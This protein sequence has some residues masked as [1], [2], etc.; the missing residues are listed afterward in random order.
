MTLFLYVVRTIAVYTLA[1]VV[2]ITTLYILFDII[3]ASRLLTKLGGGAPLLL[4][5]ASDRVAAALWHVLPASVLVGGCLAL[6][7]LARRGE[8][9]AIAA[10]G[11]GPWALLAPALLV[12]CLAATASYAV[13]ELW[14][15]GANRR[16]QS[17]LERAIV[18]GSGASALS[19]QGVWARE[20]AVLVHTGRMGA[21]VGEGHEVTLFVLDAQF[22]PVRRI[23]AQRM[24]WVGSRRVEGAVAGGPWLLEGAIERSFV[25]PDGT[26][27]APTFRKHS[28]LRAPLD[29][30]P[31]RLR[32]DL[33]RPELLRIG[34]LRAVAAWR[35]EQGQ[36]AYSFEAAFAER[37]SWPLLAIG[38]VLLLTP[39][40]LRSRASG[41]PAAAL[42]RAVLIAASYAAVAIA[43]QALG[44]ADVL[45]GTAVGALAPALL[46]VAGVVFAARSLRRS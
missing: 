33:G 43:V 34:E 38:F 26:G 22:R 6:G 11:R 5:Y 12:A 28:E 39:F 45:P 32:A 14:L 4:H 9:T 36:D 24:R 8:L 41:A 35:S 42:G 21:A 1:S 44:R 7:S 2:A 16:A 27:A 18:R 20:G 40:A 29:A 13:A 17:L 19:G 3:E 10:A 37:V 25:A 46:G 30:P 15:P 23:D 31:E